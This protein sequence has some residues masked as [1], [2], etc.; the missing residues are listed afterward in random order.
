MCVPTLH[1][2]VE[3]FECSERLGNGP[4]HGIIDTVHH[5]QHQLTVVDIFRT[6]LVLTS[7]NPS[8][9]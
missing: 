6:L 4:E 3:T 8:L 7:T 5:L 9:I 1:C 2:I